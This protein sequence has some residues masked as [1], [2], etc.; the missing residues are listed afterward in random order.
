MNKAVRLQRGTKNC[1]RSWRRARKKDCMKE[2][3]EEQ[4]GCTAPAVDG[5][6]EQREAK[7][8]TSPRICKNGMRP[9][10]VAFQQD[11]PI[12]EL[13]AENKEETAR[14]QTTAKLFPI[15]IET[16]C[17]TTAAQGTWPDHIP[18]ERERE[19]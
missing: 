4:H 9:S 11:P 5:G 8:T 16:H 13:I 12:R 6:A 18:R 2:Y 7:R 10:G 14:I 1:A 19:K 17:C 15:T 3:V